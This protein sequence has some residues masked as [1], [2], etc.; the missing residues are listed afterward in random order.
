MVASAIYVLDLKGKVLISRV[1]RSDIPANA[2]EKFMPLLL[3]QEEENG[4]QGAPPVLTKD[5]VNYLFIKH[6]NLYCMLYCFPV[7]I[8]Y[9]THHTKQCWL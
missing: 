9:T 7:L 4:D 2:V 8:M 5:G 3:E 1:Y 6:N